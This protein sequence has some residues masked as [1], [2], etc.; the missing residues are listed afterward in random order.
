MYLTEGVII[1][2]KYNFYQKGVKTTILEQVEDNPSLGTSTYQIEG[3]SNEMSHFNV[4]VNNTVINYKNSK[5]L[6]HEY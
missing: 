1:A 5:K 6:Y 3:K 4:G 2:L